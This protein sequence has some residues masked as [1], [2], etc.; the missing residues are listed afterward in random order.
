MLLIRISKIKTIFILIWSTLGRLHAVTPLERLPL[1]REIHLWY[2]YSFWCITVYILGVYILQSPS[3]FNVS[4]LVHKI[5][6]LEF[7]SISCQGH[8]AFLT[9]P[10]K[11]VSI[12]GK[13][14]HLQKGCT[15]SLAFYEDQ[16]C[17]SNSEFR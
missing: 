15:I 14:S 6:Y 12:D 11:S 4:I 8:C 10:P 17:K 5:H 9:S 16:S 13:K 2:F 3:N 1:S 7:F